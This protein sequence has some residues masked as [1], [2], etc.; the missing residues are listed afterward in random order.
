NAEP[1]RSDLSMQVVIIDKVDAVEVVFGFSEPIESLTLSRANYTN[2]HT[3]MTATLPGQALENGVVTLATPGTTVVVRILPDLEE[4]NSIYPTM[5]NIE[6]HGNLIF[7]PAILPEIRIERLSGIDR[8][9]RQIRFEP[10]VDSEGY[11]YVGIPGTE[12]PD[13]EFIVAQGAR[14]DLAV[15]IENQIEGL[16]LY[17]TERMGRS[18][19]L[20]P[21]FLLTTS[22]DER[23]YNRGDV[24]EN[25]V[26]FLRYRLPEQENLSVDTKRLSA[27][28]LAHEIFHLWQN[29]EHAD[30]ST[31]WLH[32]GVAEFASV[33]ALDESMPH[34]G[35]ANDRL[36][37][38]YNNCSNTVLYHE[39]QYLSSRN[40]GRARYSCGMLVQWLSSLEMQKHPTGPDIWTLWR[41]LWPAGESY[42]TT[43][44]DFRALGEVSFP[45]AL[46]QADTIFS[47]EGT[48]RWVN[49]FETVQAVV[50]VVEEPE[51]QFQ[52]RVMIAR[53]LVLSACGEFWGAGERNGT[54][55]YV[56]VPPEC[57]TFNDGSAIIRIDGLDPMTQLAESFSRVRSACSAEDKVDV[58]ISQDGMTQEASVRCDVP[59]QLPPPVMAMSVDAAVPTPSLIAATR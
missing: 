28:F 8:S 35:R 16:L 36:I 7:A 3:R 2:P 40:Q 55:L 47:G 52:S 4:V 37:A 12:T 42:G 15:E 34:L 29:R 33:L 22:Y 1:N 9:G 48:A 49:I 14:S 13:Y 11:L 38:S 41:E 19:G 30:P 26:I 53:S 46:R 21:K 32:E 58:R 5:S 27:E 6:G 39:F 24:T 18:A 50:P 23:P 43:I 54:E 57:D 20:K 56:S 44:A 45:S 51:N 31:W 10:S 25:G 59:V 17:Y